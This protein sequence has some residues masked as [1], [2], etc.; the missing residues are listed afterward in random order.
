ML[1]RVSTQSVRKISRFGMPSAIML[2]SLVAGLVL[3]NGG[4]G[5]GGSLGGECMIDSDCSGEWICAYQFC[6]QQCTSSKDCGPGEICFKN[7]KDPEV[8]GYCD[9]PR[10]CRKSAECNLGIDRGQVCREDTCRDV[11]LSD[12]DCMGDQQCFSQVCYEICSADRPCEVEGEE[13]YENRCAQFEPEQKPGEID[14][15]CDLPSQCESL[16]C[17]NEKCVGCKEDIDCGGRRCDNPAPGDSSQGKCASSALGDAPEMPLKMTEVTTNDYSVID[18]IPDSKGQNIYFCG[19]KDGVNGYGS[20]I[21]KAT[22]G[23]GITQVAY[24]SSL[25]IHCQQIAIS[26]DDKT[27]YVGW[28]NT[29]LTQHGIFKLNI[30]P[31]GMVVPF[32]PNSGHVEWVKNAPV[33]VMEVRTVVDENMIKKDMIYISAL[34]PGNYYQIL[35]GVQDQLTPD[36]WSESFYGYSSSLAAMGDRIIVPLGSGI[37]DSHILAVI[38]QG[39]EAEWLSIT[40]TPIASNWSA[41][42]I[43]KEED[44]L[45]WPG[46][47]PFGT[48]SR[49]FAIRPS[50][51]QVIEQYVIEGVPEATHLRRARDKNVFA[52]TSEYGKLY[53]FEL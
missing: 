11:C 16:N 8:P 25:D 5:C 40:S 10:E 44:R 21:F 45:Y 53:T 47:Q 7:E 17:I 34:T 15:P 36:L 23:A 41:V 49:L 29:S 9:K 51:G 37:F 3:T 24:S 30:D 50:T 33:Y 52:W 4:L 28:E 32:P 39:E 46:H 31:Q 14:M 1:D 22:V 48:G 38:K 6:H 2:L 43:N 35:S 13:C 42:A 19:S 20:G 26:H 18:A 12:S 27:L